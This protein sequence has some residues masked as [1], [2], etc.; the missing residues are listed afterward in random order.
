MSD[1]NKL[2]IRCAFTSLYGWKG[3][4]FFTSVYN[5]TWGP[6]TCTPCTGT[7]TSCIRNGRPVGFGFCNPDVHGFYLNDQGIPGGPGSNP[8]EVTQVNVSFGPKSQEAFI[9]EYQTG[10]NQNISYQLETVG[11][12]Y[13]NASYYFKPRPVDYYNNGKP[14]YSASALG[15]SPAVCSGLCTAADVACKLACA[16]LPGNLQWECKPACESKVSLCHKACP[17]VQT[18]MELPT[19]SGRVDGPLLQALATVCTT[20]SKP[21]PLMAVYTPKDNA[22]NDDKLDQPYEV[23][24]GGVGAAVAFKESLAPYGTVID[25]ITDWWGGFEATIPPFAALI[26]QPKD[27]TKASDAR[28]PGEATST[29][30]KNIENVACFWQP[31]LIFAWRSTI[32]IV[33]WIEDF[34]FAPSLCTPAT[35]TA[36]QHCPGPSPRLHWS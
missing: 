7:R 32:T 10:E 1:E 6:G 13:G 24:P 23:T 27:G 2:F 28:A 14:S 4:P 22:E 35:R 26:V 15:V 29:P 17:E 18:K 25:S 16:A 12:T 20:L 30:C 36:L 34:A 5:R 9:D 8:G 3:N 31:I 33:D 21:P 11:C 19:I